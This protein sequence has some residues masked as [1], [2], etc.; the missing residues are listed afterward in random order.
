MW[1]VGDSYL[2][3]LHRQK[4]RSAEAPS[5]VFAGS[6]K[7]KR[8]RTRMEE[9]YHSLERR[10]GPA[11]VCFVVGVRVGNRRRNTTT[12][13]KMYGPFPSLRHRSGGGR[14]TL[15]GTWRSERNFQGETDQ[16][17]RRQFPFGRAP[18]TPKYVFFPTAGVMRSRSTDDRRPG[19]SR[20]HWQGRWVTGGVR[21]AH[22]SE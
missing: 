15:A 20:R 4:R 18:N 11:R 5:W 7:K 2:S 9:E 8:E 3:D 12:G 17:A 13:G 21:R 16:C 6:Q 1:V 19:T 14:G 22:R 10:E